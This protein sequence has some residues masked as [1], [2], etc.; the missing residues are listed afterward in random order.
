MSDIQFIM[1][2]R[3][4][5]EIGVEDYSSIKKYF[6][7]GIAPNDFVVDLAAM[8][9]NSLL[10]RYK[11]PSKFSITKQKHEAIKSL[12]KEFQ[13]SAEYTK[14][15][16]WISY[17]LKDESYALGIS[18]DLEKDT[19]IQRERDA[20]LKFLTAGVVIQQGVSN[21]GNYPLNEVFY[22]PEVRIRGIDL[23]PQG[24]KHEFPWKRKVHTINHAPF[25]REL[26]T[27]I[28]N[29]LKK[30]QKKSGAKA[31]SFLNRL[32]GE[33]GRLMRTFLVDELNFS[34]DRSIEFIAKFYFHIG[35]PLKFKA[36]S[37][38]A[39]RTDPVVTKKNPYE[40]DRSDYVKH[41]R[42]ILKTQ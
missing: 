40:L 15:F 18:R 10:E 28:L 11:Y 21:S 30:S 2:P 17:R 33:W 34:S 22:F 32:L 29:H 16:S 4:D 37:G 6:S 7:S 13:I 35:F 27:L 1:N 19:S 3:S 12:I 25:G 23:K 36:K 41:M 5:I 9:Q 42:S 8:E 38:R 39:K 20:L 14:V 26:L 31:P 24:E